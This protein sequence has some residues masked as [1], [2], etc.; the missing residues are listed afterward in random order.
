MSVLEW[1]VRVN[2]QECAMGCS[3]CSCMY[4]VTLDAFRPFP[5]YS[6]TTA[7]FYCRRLRVLLHEWPP[8]HTHIRIIFS[9]LNLLPH[10]TC[11]CGLLQPRFVHFR[12]ICLT[13]SVLFCVVFS[14]PFALSHCICTTLCFYSQHYFVHLRLCTSQIQICVMISYPNTLPIICTFVSL[15]SQD[16]F[17][18][19]WFPSQ[20][21][22]CVVFFPSI[23]PFPY[24][25]T[26]MVLYSED[27]FTSESFASQ[28]QICL[29]FSP[30]LCPFPLCLHD[31]GF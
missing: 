13:N 16:L 24:V 3:D 8:S 20:I 26:I 22:I 10:C 1:N 2:E 6:C 27:L 11:N 15:Y 9:H 12:V 30:P 14:H 23:W 25:C 17:T 21:Q 19:E 18:W 4:W 29:V 7:G 31:C 5:H 28:I